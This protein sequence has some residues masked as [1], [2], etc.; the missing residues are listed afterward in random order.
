M[1]DQGKKPLS[2]CFSGHR[3]EKLPGGGKD[4][5][6][7]FRRLLSL[8]YSEILKSIDEGYTVFYTGMSRGIDL[9]AAKF[10]IEQ[11]FSHPDIKL[12]CAVPYRGHGLELL[13]LE[14][15]DYS[16]I[17]DAADKVV[18][19]SDSYDRNCMRRRNEYMVNHSDKLIAIIKDKKS[20]TGMTV[21]LARKKGISVKV[22][23]IGS[24]SPILD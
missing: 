19:V 15:W 9:W 10:V 5:D 12:I 14:K 17:L 4:T 21:N 13:G 7:G 11:R 18:Y 2:L 8:L 3:P 22:I 6:N 16:T 20:G 23:D 1:S 24:I